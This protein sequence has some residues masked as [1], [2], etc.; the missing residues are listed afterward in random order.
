MI[1]NP[2]LKE[3]ELIERTLKAR[4]S[5]VQMKITEH[6]SMFPQIKIEAWDG[7]GLYEEGLYAINASPDIVDKVRGITCGSETN[8]VTLN[9]GE[10]IIMEEYFSENEIASL[11]R[12]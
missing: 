4:L 8:M 11:R 12:V 1:K 3:L 9:S 6:L 7:L 10:K 5:A 2:T